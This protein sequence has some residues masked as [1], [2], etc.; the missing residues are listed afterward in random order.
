MLTLISVSTTPQKFQPFVALRT[1]LC[2]GGDTMK[3]SIALQMVLMLEG[4]ECR[5][6]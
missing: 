3:V 1:S 2:T 4:V 6:K 5:A